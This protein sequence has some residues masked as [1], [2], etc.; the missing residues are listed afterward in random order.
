LDTSSK[1]NS[2]TT[3]PVKRTNADRAVKV[4]P[5]L[6]TKTCT[7][8]AKPVGKSDATPKDDVQTSHNKQSNNINANSSASVPATAGD[9]NDCSIADYCAMCNET[10][11]DR[12]IRCDICNC[13]VHS[14][15]FGICDN[16]VDK[17]LDTV[18]YA[19]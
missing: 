9:P 17:L 15:C 19:G 7:V 18:Q 3:K 11:D 12:S 6:S 13:L 4:K 8:T 5:T 10:A 2:K 1:A 16:V 14:M